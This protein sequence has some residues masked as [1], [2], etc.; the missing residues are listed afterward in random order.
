MTTGFKN[1]KQSST[2][3]TEDEKEAAD[4]TTKTTTHT[5]AVLQNSKNSTWVTYGTIVLTPDSIPNKVV[6]VVTACVVFDGSD[7]IGDV[8]LA[9]G[10]TLIGTAK[11][12][13]TT[14]SF[15]RRSGTITNVLD[16]V[17]IAAHTYQVQ[18]KG[19]G[20]VHISS[21]DIGGA[22]IDLE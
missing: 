8:R 3:G 10:G 18:C 9:E 5:L 22:V 4:N 6:I 14:V 16:D 17:S 11:A 13:D 12:L 1:A 15:G 21:A 7:V 2:L 19:D 20:N